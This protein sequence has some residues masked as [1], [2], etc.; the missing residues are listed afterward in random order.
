MAKSCPY[1]GEEHQAVKNHVRLTGRG[2]HGSPG[3]YPEGFGEDHDQNDSPD[4]GG[5]T[6]DGLGLDGDRDDH[7]DG[8]QPAPMPTTDGGAGAVAVEA[9]DDAESNHSP[10]LDED[11]DE[12]EEEELIAMPESELNTMLQE[13]ADPETTDVG[14]TET[15]SMDETVSPV[16]ADESEESGGSGW[17]W[18][19]LLGLLAL[20]GGVFW[21]AAKRNQNSGQQFQQLTP[22]DNSEIHFV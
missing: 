13:A 21:Q 1:C 2:G 8:S 6:G 12:D 16:E 20:V 22:H 14:D 10:V 3:Q 15:E 7:A 18:W 5:G 9:V 11:E 4:P 19:I 17:V